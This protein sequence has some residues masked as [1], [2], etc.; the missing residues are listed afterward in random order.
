MG[1]GENYFRFFDGMT[2]RTNRPV[3]T[4]DGAGVVEESVGGGGHPVKD[5]PPATP[6]VVEVSAS[7]KPAKSTKKDG[8]ESK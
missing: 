7:R 2:P 4:D 6:K 8:E 1:Y 5:A 3:L